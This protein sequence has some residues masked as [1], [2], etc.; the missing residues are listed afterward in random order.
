MVESDTNPYPKGSEIGGLLPN[1]A[2]DR[3]RLLAEAK[4]RAWAEG[5]D[6][7]RAEATRLREAL[8]ACAANIE[9]TGEWGMEALAKTRA[10]LTTPTDDDRALVERV[11]RH[12]P[13]FTEVTPPTDQGEG[14]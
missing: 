1:L 12:S 4:H 13:T 14:A 6:A 7:A 3:E 2:G 5:Y 11:T 10:A 8:E 9:E